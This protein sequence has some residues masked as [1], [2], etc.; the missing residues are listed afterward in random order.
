M[1]FGLSLC[2]VVG[3]DA[4]FFCAWPNAH[5]SHP[6]SSATSTSAFAANLVPVLEKGRKRGREVEK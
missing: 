2:G 6:V 1:R 5:M 3:N 4:V